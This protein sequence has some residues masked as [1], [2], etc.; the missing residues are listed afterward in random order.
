M[1]FKT[2]KNVAIIN[3]CDDGS[4]GKIGLNLLESFCEKG[5]NA[6]FFYGRGKKNRGERLYRIDTNLEF[7]IHALLSRITGLQGAFSLFATV[8][9]IRKFKSKNIDTI[10]LLS[11]HGC[12]LN[13]SLLFKYIIR[14]NIPL[15]YIMVDQYAYLGNCTNLPSCSKY[16]DGCG[17]CPNIKAFPPSWFFDTCST[18][19][20]RKERAYKLLNKVQ[21][22]GPQYVIDS[23]KDTILGRYMRT[24]VLDEAIDVSL[25][26]P[27]ETC[28][29][30]VKHHISPDKK[31]ILCVAP[32]NNPIK[33]A[34]FFIDV[35][36]RFEK[37][38]GY[39]FIHIGYK[40]NAP[41]VQSSNF[42]PIPFV[43]QDEDLAKYY[44]LADLFVFPS[45]CDT[46]SN[47]C[48]EAMSCGTPLLCFNVSGMPYLLD[49]TV[50]ELVE[51]GDIA[52]ME[53]VIRQ[54]GKKNQSIINRCRKYALSRYDSRQYASKLISIADNL[55]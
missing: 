18:L 47:T 24:S 39:V 15:I 38:N 52:A 10:F 46:M 2:M 50:G 33:G 8:R 29:L 42:I 55:K 16:K 5:Y 48:I 53:R 28:E 26:S 12:Y 6:Y 11:P 17:A 35:V 54:C 21:F 40:T 27:K 37:E 51:V 3:T 20:K 23:S 9:M 41:L 49:N 4:T 19:L 43:E 34:K 13:E 14:N 31:I 1:Y 22:V 25:Y 30:L 7:L 45:I 44:S 32:S 36:K